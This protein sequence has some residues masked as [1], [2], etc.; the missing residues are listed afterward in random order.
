V[1]HFL[2]FFVSL[3]RRKFAERRHERPAPQ[4]PQ[5][6][7]GNMNLVLFGF[8]SGDYNRIQPPYITIFKTS[9]LLYAL[10][11]EDT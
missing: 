4:T 5:F 2:L 8:E 1:L 7:G 9:F 6:E 10:A 11:I 3:L